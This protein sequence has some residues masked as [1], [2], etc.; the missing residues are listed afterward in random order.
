MCSRGFQPLDLRLQAGDTQRLEAGAT[1]ITKPPAT[2]LPG[3][4]VVCRFTRKL[5]VFGAAPIFGPI[6]G[7][8]CSVPGRLARAAFGEEMNK[9]G[10]KSVA[11]GTL[12][13]ASA[14]A[15]AQSID[16]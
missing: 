14:A 13:A 1:V 6:L 11:L 7:I 2:Y 3:L 12:A 10:L 15:A 9:R 4:S 8:P 16:L 5:P